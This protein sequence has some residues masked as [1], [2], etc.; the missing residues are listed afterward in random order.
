MGRWLGKIGGK[1]QKCVGEVDFFKCGV[2]LVI[3]GANF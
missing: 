2:K 1:A 3:I